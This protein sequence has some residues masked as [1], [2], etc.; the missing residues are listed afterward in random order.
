M[1][2]FIWNLHLAIYPMTLFKYNIV[3]DEFKKTFL[4]VGKIT[5]IYCN[6]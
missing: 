5:I 2:C 6:L 4:F 3:F 1:S